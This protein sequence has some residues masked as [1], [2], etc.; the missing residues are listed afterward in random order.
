MMK[1]KM[2]KLFAA[3]AAVALV[4]TS[5]APVFA[6]KSSHLPDPSETGSITVHKYAT[7]AKS[8]TPGNGA[9]ITDQNKLNKLGEPLKDV[10]FTLYKIPNAEVKEGLTPA[11]AKAKAGA[12]YRAEQLTDASGVTKFDNLPVGYYV[13]VESKKPTGRDYLPMDDVIISV[14]YGVNPNGSREGWNYDVHV[15][16]KN[17]LN[18]EII[19]EEESVGPKYNVGDVVTWSLRAK[20]NDSLKNNTAYGKMKITDTLDERLTYL[21]GQDVVQGDKANG[22]KVTLSAAAGDFTVSVTNAADGSGRRV[23][24]WEFNEAQVKKL[25]DKGIESVKITFKT[26]IN[27]K[28]AQVNNSVI[29]NSGQK[30][31]QNAGD[32]KYGDPIDTPNPPKIYLGGVIVKKVYA[33]DHT[34][35]LDGAQFKIAATEQDAKDGNFIKVGYDNTK[36]HLIITTGDDPETAGEQHGYGK[37]SGLRL[38]PTGDTTF[39]LVEVKAPEAPAGADYEYVLRPDIIAVT[40][41]AGEKEGTAVVENTRTGEDGPGPIFKLPETGGMGT[42]I[43]TIVGLTLIGGSIVVLMKSKKGKETK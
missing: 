36:E 30:Q 26:E 6:D 39:Y 21:T 17:V 41:K 10:G 14:P 18:E 35:L 25:F 28:A 11:E 20:V 37:F 42:L 38:N 33:K 23:V 1:G 24:T 22:D 15:Y 29:E 12:P 43:F 5:A 7:N 16:P 19:K 31:L 9:E 40:I 3:I 27:E 8:T 2:K 4:A 13:L 34:V 32:T